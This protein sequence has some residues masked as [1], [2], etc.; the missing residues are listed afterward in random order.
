VSRAIPGGLCPTRAVEW[1]PFRASLT[2]TMHFESHM[3][4]TIGLPLTLSD[5]T[6]IPIS[7]AVQTNGLLFV[8][9]Q[10]AIAADGTVSGSAREQTLIC[11]ERIKAILEASGSSLDEVV[12]V[13]AWLADLGDFYEFN[14]AYGEVFHSA[15][16]ARS[17]VQ[18]RLMFGA[19]VEI[20]V[21]ARCGE[22][23]DVV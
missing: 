17:T 15:Y 13:T 4:N 5:G 3:K 11:L 16:P 7:K 12:K 21:V 19:R 23:S 2:A 1:A 20:E 6:V 9:G 8:S 18:S 14:R 22:S 10:L